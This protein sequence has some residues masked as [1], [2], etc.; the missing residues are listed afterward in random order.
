M[1]ISKHQEIRTVI[2]TISSLLSKSQVRVDKKQLI[3]SSASLSCK[4]ASSFEATCL[5][6]EISVSV[7]KEL[8]FSSENANGS[9]KQA[10]QKPC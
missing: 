8:Q 4:Q 2:N 1:L 9:R 10:T 3:I 6:S 7:L 5:C